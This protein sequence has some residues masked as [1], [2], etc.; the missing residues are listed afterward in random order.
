MAKIKWVLLSGIMFLLVSGCANLKVYRTNSATPAK[1]EELKGIPFYIKVP[2]ATQETKLL[3]RELLVKVDLSLVGPS[4]PIR[5][6]SFPTSGPLRVNDKPEVRRGIDNEIGNLL[7]AGASA[8]TNFEKTSVEIVKALE[9]IA[10]L[11]PK[12][13]PPSLLS[14]SWSLSMVVGPQPHYISGKIPFIG[15]ATSNFKFSADGTLS[16]ANSTVTDD[17]AKTLLSLF[18][19]AQKLTDQW[20]LLPADAKE[21]KSAGMVVPN[22]EIKVE[23]TVAGATTTYTLKKVKELTGN[24]SAGKFFDSAAGGPPLSLAEALNGTNDV[25]L[26]SREIVEGKGNGGGAKPDAEAYQFE[27][28]ITPP[29]PP[30]PG[31]TDP[32][33]GPVIQ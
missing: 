24:P 23:V 11:S 29:K 7:T 14:N 15:S 26:V 27:G 6:A 30:K 16:E 32:G 18:P 19:I 25:Q 20:G 22:P 13:E 8:N 12:P 4:G 5:T 10:K 2:V 28:T 33:K 17:T 21:I 1:T 3:Q 9:K 31:N